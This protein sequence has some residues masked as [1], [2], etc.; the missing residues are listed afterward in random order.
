MRKLRTGELLNVPEI[1]EGLALY[2][3]EKDAVFVRSRSTSPL[4]RRLI[5]SQRAFDV[6]RGVKPPSLS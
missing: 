3:G 6:F 2:H 1:A 4:G 5:S